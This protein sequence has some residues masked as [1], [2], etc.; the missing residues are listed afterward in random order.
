MWEYLSENSRQ[1]LTGAYLEAGKLGVSYLGSEHIMLAILSHRHNTACRELKTLGVDLADFREKL[2]GKVKRQPEKNGEDIT[3]SA[4]AARILEISLA[5]TISLEKK[6]IGTE[7]ILLALMK[8]GIGI[9]ANILRND[10]GITVE[11]ILEE[12]YG[13]TNLE[14]GSYTAIRDMTGSSL[15]IVEEKIQSA[16]IQKKVIQGKADEI[17]HVT[18]YLC[19]LLESVNRSDIRN[20]VELIKKRIIKA[21]GDESKQEQATSQDIPVESAVQ[22]QIT[23]NSPQTQEVSVLPSGQGITI[24]IHIDKSALKNI[25]RDVVNESG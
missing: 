15:R 25:I 17:L 7:H 23:G 24:S 3:F 10:Y 11:T 19:D 5:I 20:D 2:L 13:I 22:L 18:D 21:F 4:R 14:S 1:I 9:P 6:L 16:N 12:L 8:E